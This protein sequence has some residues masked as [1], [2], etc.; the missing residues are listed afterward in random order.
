V[1]RFKVGDH[2]AHRDDPEDCG[3]IIALVRDTPAGPQWRID[4]DHHEGTSDLA[5]QA[6]VACEAPEES[7]EETEELLDSN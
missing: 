4:W 7:D 2:V 5:E 6:L 3:M 1:A